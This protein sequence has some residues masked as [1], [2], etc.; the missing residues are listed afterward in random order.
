MPSSSGDRTGKWFSH[1]PFAEFREN[2]TWEPTERV[3][4]LSKLLFHAPDPKKVAFLIFGLGLIIGLLIDFGPGGLVYGAFVFA[5]AAYASAYFSM[6][7]IEYYGERFFL[8]RSMLTSFMGLV[9]VAFVLVIGK[10]LHPFLGLGWRFLIIYG[11]CLDLAMRYLVIRTSCIKHRQFTFLVSS[12]TMVFVFFFFLPFAFLETNILPNNNTPSW[13]ETRFIILSVLSLLGTTFLFTEVIN[14]P[15]RNE[16]GL[17]S[18]DLLGYFLSY[19]TIGSRELEILFHRMEEEMSVPLKTLVFRRIND[20]STK[21]IGLLPGVHPG[22][23]GDLGGGDLPAKMQ[24]FLKK[25]H[26]DVMCFHGCSSN[27]LDPV[28][29]DECKKVSDVAKKLIEETQDYSSTATELAT[30]HDDSS[31]SVQLFGD[32]ALVLHE[33]RQ[34][35][36]DDIN[37]ATGVLTEVETKECGIRESVFVDCHNHASK[38][39]RILDLG[40]RLSRQIVE[41][42]VSL[43]EKQKIAK[44]YPFRLGYARESSFSKEEGIGSMGVQTVVLELDMTDSKN[45]EGPSSGNTS[46]RIAYVLCD[47]NNMVSEFKKAAEGLCLEFVDSASIMTTDNHVVNAVMGGYNPIGEKTELEVFLAAI[48]KSLASA[49]DDLEPVEVGFNS[50]EVDDIKV[51]GHGNALRL[52]TVINNTVA[53]ARHALLPFLILAFLSSAMAYY[54]A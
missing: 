22:P 28:S 6:R 33:S 10:L 36:V 47:G 9:I 12:L 29:N 16:F 54:L 19:M 13:E 46:H 41:N 2:I 15:M 18:T 43:T 11:Y 39:A 31:L 37:P 23:V 51:I 24:Q 34:G 7:L 53:L 21:L 44:Q 25:R 14:A 26:V 5:F 1:T 8:R 30:L 27:D 38:K 49:L 52:A 4:T 48:R 17:S 40:H 35:L 45:D 20:K 50:G 3:T 42:T 32:N